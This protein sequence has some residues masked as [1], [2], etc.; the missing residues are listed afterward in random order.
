MLSILNP[1]LCKSG[2]RLWWSGLFILWLEIRHKHLP[3]RKFWLVTLKW[4]V[5]K[6]IW[7]VSI[8]S[9]KYWAEFLSFLQNLFPYYIL[10][11]TPEAWEMHLNSRYRRLS[12]S[13]SRESYSSYHTS[14]IAY[15]T[16]F[17]VKVKARY[18]HSF[19]KFMPLLPIT[20][21]TQNNIILKRAT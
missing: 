7:P 1:W 3:D 21:S 10:G 5:Q 2:A 13:S 6:E 9:S 15:L 14:H 16:P 17:T 8:F 12:T 20:S 11:G 4:A 18:H 19:S